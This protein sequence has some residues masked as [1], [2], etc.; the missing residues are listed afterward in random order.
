MLNDRDN[1]KDINSILSEKRLYKKSTS[2]NTFT[3]FVLRCMFSEIDEFPDIENQYKEKTNNHYNGDI[4]DKIMIDIL[5]LNG[6]IGEQ[7]I[8]KLVYIRDCFLPY[9]RIIRHMGYDQLEINYDKYKIDILKKILSS[10]NDI[11]TIYRI[12]ECILFENIDCG[13]LTEDEYKNLQNQGNE[14]I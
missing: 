9:M 10:E 2:F 5:K 11:E 12:T 14:N 6:L 1:L 4:S 8:F 3:P 7:N 13:I